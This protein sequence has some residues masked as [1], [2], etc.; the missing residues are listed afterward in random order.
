MPGANCA[1]NS[2][3]LSK[4]L[5]IAVNQAQNWGPNYYIKFYLS[6][7]LGGYMQ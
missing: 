7:L 5:K 4:K 2:W 1:K 6:I 3:D